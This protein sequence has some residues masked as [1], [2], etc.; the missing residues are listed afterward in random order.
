VT[1]QSPVGSAESGPGEEGIRIEWV[2]PLLEAGLLHAPIENDLAALPT[3]H[4]VEALLEVGD[5]PT[6]G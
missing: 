4:G 2:D 3:A 6:A 5:V 1:E